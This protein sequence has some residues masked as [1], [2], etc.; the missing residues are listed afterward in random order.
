MSKK[1]K[2]VSYEEK[3]T[4]ILGIYHEKKEVLNLKELEK[5]GE[6][7]KQI[8]IIIIYDV[9]EKERSELRRK[10]Y[11]N[12]WNLSRKERGAESERT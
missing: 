4:R 9:K 11:K 10:T 12:T 2:G 7:Q 8:Y 5:L 1:R 6:K 3:R